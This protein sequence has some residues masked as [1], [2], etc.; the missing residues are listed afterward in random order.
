MLNLGLM[1]RFHFR[2]GKSLN[3]EKNEFLSFVASL[4]GI[5]FG[6]DTAVISGTITA[7]GEQFWLDAMAKGWEVGLT[8][9]M[10]KI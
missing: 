10:N 3:Y 8:V 2:L 7:V 9:P 5:L 6:Y 1:P 4:G